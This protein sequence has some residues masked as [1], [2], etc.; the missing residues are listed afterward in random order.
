MMATWVPGHFKNI[1]GAPNSNPEDPG[2]GSVKTRIIATV[3]SVATPVCD[4]ETKRFNHKA[5]RLPSV[6]VVCVS[7]DLP[8]AQKR[9]CQGALVDKVTTVSDHRDAS[10]SRS[11]GV[12]IEGGHSIAWRRAPCS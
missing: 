7:M 12:L 1:H 11:Y 5:A 9:W 6:G 8:F 3:P 2:R 4:R 10:F